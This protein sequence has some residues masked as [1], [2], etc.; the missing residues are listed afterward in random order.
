MGWGATLMAKKREAL[1]F[2]IDDLLQAT[3]EYLGGVKAGAGVHA[4]DDGPSDQASIE[5]ATGWELDLD[6]GHGW[7]FVIKASASSRTSAGWPGNITPSLSRAPKPAEAEA[8]ADAAHFIFSYMRPALTITA[9]GILAGM[10][11]HLDSFDL[12]EAAW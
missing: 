5:A 12:P 8:G 4:P 9:C 2:V 3:H 1:D 11:R 10:L 7:R 6:E